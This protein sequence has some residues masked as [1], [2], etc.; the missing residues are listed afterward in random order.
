M[1]HRDQALSYAGCG[2]RNEASL[3]ICFPFPGNRQQNP[4]YQSVAH[5]NRSTCYQP[6]RASSHLQLFPSELDNERVRPCYGDVG[7]IDVNNVINGCRSCSDRMSTRVSMNDN[8]MNYDFIHNG[9]V[10]TH[11]VV[12]QHVHTSIFCETLMGLFS[13][14]IAMMTVPMTTMVSAMPTVPAMTQQQDAEI[15]SRHMASTSS[16]CNCDDKDYAYDGERSL[17]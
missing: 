3:S 7:D 6:L 11:N 16:P 14:L 4:Q 17:F 15:T 2:K 13:Q 1:P 5:S 12:G 8:V 9:Y 10:M